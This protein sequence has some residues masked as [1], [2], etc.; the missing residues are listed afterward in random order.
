MASA[1][2]RAA[3]ALHE[4]RSTVPWS[5]LDGADQYNVEKQARAV[6][7]AVRVPPSEIAEAGYQITGYE[8]NCDVT[9]TAMID[10]ILNEKE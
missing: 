6:L 9:F 8:E 10:A 2:E 7:M 3:R 1:L 4:S 5:W